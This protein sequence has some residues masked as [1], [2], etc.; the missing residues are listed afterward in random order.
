VITGGRKA[1]TQPSRRIRREKIQIFE[2]IKIAK[3]A[4]LFED[5]PPDEDSLIA[6][7]PAAQSRANAGYSCHSRRACKSMQAS[8]IGR[9]KCT[10]LQ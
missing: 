8:T 10:A 9:R 3:T 1:M 7:K 5:L 6:E 2:K 4:E